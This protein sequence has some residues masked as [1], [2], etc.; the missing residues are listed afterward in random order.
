ML[1]S[2]RLRVVCN[3]GGLWYCNASDNLGNSHGERLHLYGP[4]LWYL[5]GAKDKLCSVWRRR[6]KRHDQGRLMRAG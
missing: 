1:E 6:D 4:L 3:R 2:K 5:S